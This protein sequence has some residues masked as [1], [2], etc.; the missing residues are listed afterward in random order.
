[1]AG[2]KEVLSLVIL[3]SALMDV[4]FVRLGFHIRSQRGFCLRSLSEGGALEMLGLKG[5]SSPE[6]REL[7]QAFRRQALEMH[8][9][10][11]GSAE[12]FRQLLEA[13]TFL[14]RSLRRGL[15]ERGKRLKEGREKWKKWEEEVEGGQE[16]AQEGDIVYWRNAQ[17]EPWQVALVLAV[18]V[19]YE[20]SSGPHGWIYL[21]SLIQ[22]S[23]GTFDADEE[24]EMEQ[25]EPVSLD[26]VN[27]AFASS[28]EVG[29]H[30]WR[31]S[32]PEYLP[33]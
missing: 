17:G 21:Q 4:A 1:M 18:Q 10:R 2:A 31:V 28:E 30:A 25:V 8:P 32:P 14:R 9:D 29:E 13:Y 26:G 24:A 22:T 16:L 12:A 15:Q 6:L 7:Q 5:Q 11:G 19:V 3:I 23:D 27:W 33:P 20:P